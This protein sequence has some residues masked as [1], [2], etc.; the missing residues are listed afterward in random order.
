MERYQCERCKLWVEDKDIDVYHFKSVHKPHT[1]LSIQMCLRCRD[2][3]FDFIEK[4]DDRPTKKDDLV[5]ALNEMSEMIAYGRRIYATPPYEIDFWTEKAS[6]IVG[7]LR[8]LVDHL[9]ED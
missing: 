6:D 4:G 7:K 2:N 5:Q 3:V 9:P 8:G 1:L